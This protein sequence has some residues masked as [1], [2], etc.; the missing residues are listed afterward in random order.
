MRN[1]RVRQL[2]KQCKN[3]CEKQDV[4]YSKGVFRFFKKL[5]TNNLL[6]DLVDNNNN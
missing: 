1:S 2:R 4:K 3:I 6:K 5:Y